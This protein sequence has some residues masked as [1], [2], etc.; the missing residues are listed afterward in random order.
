MR[1]KTLP[2]N[3]KKKDPS[4]TKKAND[5]RKSTG[6]S[7]GKLWGWGWQPGWD[8]VLT[9]QPLKRPHLSL[10]QGLEGKGH[11]TFVHLTNEADRLV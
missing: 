10:L 7:P 8:A 4:Q 9:S 11:L 6:F 5:K 2:F 3:E 1:K